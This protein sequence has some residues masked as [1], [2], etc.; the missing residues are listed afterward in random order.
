MN[1]N[2]RYRTMRKRKTTLSIMIVVM[3]PAVLFIFNSCY[4]DYGLTTAD[5]DAVITVYDEE[6]DLQGF[7]T[8]YLDEDF[9]DLND[10]DNPS[11]PDNA[12]TFISA[13]NTEMVNYGWTAVAS[14]TEDV[15]LNLA[16]SETAYFYY[17]CYPSWGWY[18]PPYWCG[19]SYSYTGGTVIIQ[20]GDAND[21]DGE[22]NLHALWHAGINGIL[23][24]TTINL[25]QRI[26][27]AV[28]QAYIQSPY[29]DRN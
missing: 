25:I 9:I 10:P 7:T 23:N 28:A 16:Y 4:K 24:D 11:D 3:I 12:D 27:D 19:T 18:Y 13:I 15:T 29:L 26:N 14:G 20:M 21:V 17:Y 8:Y 5:Y 22:G 2:P 1:L 6:E